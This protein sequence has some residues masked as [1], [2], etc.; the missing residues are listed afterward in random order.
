MDTAAYN[1][2]RKI[3]TDDD[4]QYIIDDLL[5]PGALQYITGK[6]RSRE[7]EPGTDFNFAR[8][9]DPDYVLASAL[10]MPRNLVVHSLAQ[11]ITPKQAYTMAYTNREAAE[12][13]WALSQAARKRAVQQIFGNDF[14]A[15]LPED[16]V[17]PGVIPSKL[18]YEG[19]EELRDRLRENFFAKPIYVDNLT[20]VRN[21]QMSDS[22]YYLPF[23]S[24]INNPRMVAEIADVDN[25]LKYSGVV[26][27]TPRPRLASRLSTRLDRYM[28]PK[29]VRMHE[30]G[31]H[32]ATLP[33]YVPNP[34][35]DIALAY[36]P[37]ISKLKNI[38][39]GYGLI[40]TELL[41]GLHHLKAAYNS[42]Y[43]PER[44]AEDNMDRAME[45]LSGKKLLDSKTG[46][47]TDEIF[48]ANGYS[49]P[50]ST[51]NS[52]I[53]AKQLPKDM[54]DAKKA[55]KQLDKDYAESMPIAKNYV[56]DDT[57]RGIA[58]G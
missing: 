24:I 45:Q 20:P 3:A 34:I 32:G 10:G 28:T 22:P 9:S 8:L 29:A 36:R 1:R 18:V 39:G 43:Y 46:L 25:P 38:R 4:S 31:G 5:H 41:G 44:L 47:L 37:I 11:R 27:T 58:H 55:Q 42:K 56:D 50:A 15:S 13:D 17:Y 40:P 33:V 26:R 2:L 51:V 49:A 52:A 21:E 48:S 57:I 35:S 19:R 7:L 54:P 16:T 6:H 12:R 14:V 30:L 23:W 53:E